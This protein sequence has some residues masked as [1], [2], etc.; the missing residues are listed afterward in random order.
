MFSAALC[1]R[2]SAWPEAG[3]VN[4][5]GRVSARSIS[6]LVRFVLKMNSLQVRNE[7]N[8]SMF[9]QTLR[10][11]SRLLV[12]PRQ[13][14]LAD[15]RTHFAGSQQL[16]IGFCDV[17]PEI[18]LPNSICCGVAQNAFIDSSGVNGIYDRR[19]FV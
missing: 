17:V 12:Y 10:L 13:L 9:A 2:L 18:V 15:R 11:S 6:A 16:Q 19:Q 3:N 7:R 1:K 8:L 14:T 5:R 4:F